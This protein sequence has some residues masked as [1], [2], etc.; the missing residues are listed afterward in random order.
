MRK[1][2]SDRTQDDALHNQKQKIKYHE[3]EK[4]NSTHIEDIVNDDVIRYLDQSVDDM[5][6]QN[7]NQEEIE[8]CMYKYCN[9]V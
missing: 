9:F 5:N 8:L 7:Q 4:Q 6:V 3:K 2:K 1:R